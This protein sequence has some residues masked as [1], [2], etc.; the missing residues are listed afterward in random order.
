[1]TRW[2]GRCNTAEAMLITP[3]RREMQSKKQH[4]WYNVLIAKER[5]N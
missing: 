1:M 2:K 3:R 5:A 4:C